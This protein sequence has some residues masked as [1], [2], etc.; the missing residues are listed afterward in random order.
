GPQLPPF[1]QN[2]TEEARK[3]F[4]AIVFNKE[5]KIAE[6]KKDILTWAQKYG[7]EAEVQE[8]N[9]NLT[10]LNNELKKNVTELISALPVAIEQLTALVENEDQT[11]T[12]LVNAIKA[13]SSADHKVYRVLMFI[14]REFKPKHGGPRGPKGRGGPK[15]GDSMEGPEDSDEEFGG[16]PG[17]GHGVRSLGKGKF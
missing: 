12:E 13:R 9:T 17:I 1:L 7:V 8:F 6:Q 15:G 10:N 11:A 3:E 14:L 4:F 5:E 16:F 2:V